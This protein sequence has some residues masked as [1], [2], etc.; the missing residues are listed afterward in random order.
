MRKRFL[1][2]L[3][4]SV[5]EDGGGSQRK[6]WLS[7]FVFSGEGR[8]RLSLFLFG[9]GL[10]VRREVVIYL[11][12][13]SLVQQKLSTSSFESAI[14]KPSRGTS[15]K[16]GGRLEQ[17]GHDTRTARLM[18]RR[19]REEDK[20]PDSKSLTGLWESTPATPVPPKLC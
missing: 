5:D 8:L 16:V 3:T 9:F 19:I 1:H 6:S 18:V 20:P 10:V 17:R 11:K 15:A 2:L 13:K 14:I 12:R 7:R 4:A